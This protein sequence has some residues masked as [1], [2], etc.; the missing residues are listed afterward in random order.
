MMKSDIMRNVDRLLGRFRDELDS[1]G[2]GEFTPS[3]FGDFE[4]RF[5]YY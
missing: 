1:D 3:G 5:I 4:W 2:N